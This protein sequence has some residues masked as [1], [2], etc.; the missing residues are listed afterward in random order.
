MPADLVWLPQCS[1]CMQG[2]LFLQAAAQGFL[3]C[4]MGQCCQLHMSQHHPHERGLRP[5]RDREEARASVQLQRGS[6]ALQDC[7]SCSSAQS[8]TC[9]IYL[10]QQ[11]ISLYALQAVSAG[12][13]EIGSN[14]KAARDLAMHELAE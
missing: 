8:W 3:A 14:R 7:L 9:N 6:M 12:D 13:G 10:M 5:W 2:L 1:N 11:S 4:Q